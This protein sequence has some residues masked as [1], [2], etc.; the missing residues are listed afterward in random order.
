M[1]ML[2]ITVCKFTR[3]IPIIHD[4][5]YHVT[6]SYRE[7]K[8]DIMKIWL[9]NTISSI[10]ILYHTDVTS[11]DSYYG[12]MILVCV[13]V[14]HKFMLVS[15]QLFKDTYVTWSHFWGKLYKC[16]QNVR[17][18]ETVGDL[19]LVYL[20]LWSWAETQRFPYREVTKILFL[21]FA[22]WSLLRQN[23]NKLRDYSRYVEFKMYEGLSYR[24]GFVV[25][26]VV[27]VC[28]CVCH[29]KPLEEIPPR[30]SR[31]GIACPRSS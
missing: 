12:H 24:C 13:C 29:A 22:L 14:Q 2:H 1:Y 23:F 11:R 18:H 28:M 7:Y 5:M 9:M 19:M 10:N 30:S 21:Y 3:T 25:C 8:M 4:T 16:A 26:V 31:L 20:N 6:W 17:N 15:L 27:C